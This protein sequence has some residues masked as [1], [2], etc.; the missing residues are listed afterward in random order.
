MAISIERYLNVRSAMAGTFRPDGERLAFLTD[1]TGTYQ[2]WAV[3]VP[4]PDSPPLGPS[5]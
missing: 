4:Q 2:V 1:V 5:N 3:D